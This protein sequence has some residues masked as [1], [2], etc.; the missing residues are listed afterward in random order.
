MIDRTIKP[1]AKAVQR[2]ARITTGPSAK[3][4][5]SHRIHVARLA[6]DA[7]NGSGRPG[8]GSPTAAAA[9]AGPNPAATRDLALANESVKKLAGFTFDT[10]VFGHGSPVEGDAGQQVAAL[11]AEL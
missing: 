4:I 9:V 7:L 11:A 8:I 2:E 1:P 5:R 10:I 6:G 3:L